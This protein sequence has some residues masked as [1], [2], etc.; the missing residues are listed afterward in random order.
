MATAGEVMRELESLGTAQN[1]KVYK[2][3][4]ASDNVFGVSYANL[5]KLKKRII[6]DHD[7]ALE[8]WATGNHDARVLAAMI[9]D[10]RQADDAMLVAWV[11]DLS[12]YVIADAVSGYINQTAFVREK[13]ELWTQSDEEWV[14]TVGW[15]LLTHLALRD[16]SL[17]DSYFEPYLVIIER[18][19]HTSANR[20]R[21]AMNNAL[22]AIGMRSDVLEKQTVAAAGR[23]G[24]VDVDHGETNCKTPDAV[25]YIKKAK[26]RTKKVKA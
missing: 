22:I 23:I 5:N 9:A 16:T 2:R 7:L 21:Y 20:I 8:L 17:P 25:A 15:N 24:T 10:P 4:G 3:H 13:S 6:T 1:R 19:I 26:A 11:G 12:D 18:R 14:G